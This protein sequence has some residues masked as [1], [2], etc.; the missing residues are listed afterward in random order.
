MA[1]S[2]PPPEPRPRFA[3]QNRLTR[4]RLTRITPTLADLWD[5]AGTLTAAVLGLSV[6]IAV[7]EGVS[8]TNAWSVVV[9]ALAVAIL[10]WL[11][12]APL[13][14]VAN[15]LGGV[16]AFVLGLAVQVTAVWASL[17]YLPGLLVT[18]WWAAAWVL[19]IT[20]I[21]VAAVSWLSGSNDAGYVVSDVMR[22]GKRQAALRQ[23][24]ARRG[25]PLPDTRPPGLLV[26][27]LDGLAEPVLRQAIEGGLTP[28]MA[29]WLDSGSHEL[30]QWWAQVPATTP[31]STAGL[32]HGKADAI[33]AFR[34]W[35]PTQRRLVVTNHP[36]DAAQIEEA[37]SDGE[38]L[39]AHDGVAIST[40]FSG[41]A[42]TSMLV[43]SRTIG[44]SRG[45][46]R[47]G[48][49]Y[50]RFFTRPLVFTRAFVL[51]IGEMVKEIYQARLARVRG[52]EPRISRGGWYVLLRG[53]TNVTLRGLNTSLVAEHM[54]RGAPTIAVDFVDYDEIAH[55]AGPLRP[56]SL[57]SL[58]GLDA[59]LRT[60]ATVG[61]VAPR[62]YRI[63]V[64]SDHGQALG[65]TFEQVA[66]V[67]FSDLVKALMAAGTSPT[68]D[69]SGSVQATPERAGDGDVLA[70]GGGEDWGP[71]NTLLSQVLAPM[72]P[73]RQPIVSGPERLKQTTAK[74]GQA[75]EVGDIAVIASGNLGLIWFTHT[76]D[77]LLL[78]RI[79]QLWPNLVAGLA[80][81]P[82]IA[83]V[84]VDS[85]N[86]LL[87]VG[88]HGVRHLEGERAGE[89]DG[90]DPLTAFGIDP[91][92]A[93]RD[94]ARAARLPNTGDLL[95][96]SG[97]TRGRVHA[98]EHQVGSHGGLGGDQN[99]SMLLHPAELVRAHEEYVGS[100]AVFHQLR[101]WQREL[102]LRP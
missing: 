49:V 20:A 5:A 81:H 98:F 33:P 36:W 87:A 27:I 93:A 83:A 4:T 12:A 92:Q 30:T 99:R 26:V 8:A 18:S 42:P 16:V 95:V 32:L 91:A 2:A 15:W 17:R 59:V 86:G 96:I 6:G 43:M 3:R 58:E 46:R 62:D 60:L 82:A 14:L 90:D 48:A 1:E 52:V 75:R 39:L 40:V 71:I 65:A 35:D 78:D 7:V 85:A 38:G 28:T 100:D 31:A 23:L 63:V 66:G 53:I 41:D 37:F 19:L 64:V 47:A 72:R 9:A 69:T 101:A 50:V 76:D 61:E 10:T 11:L 74:P 55:H 68:G 45:S 29:S 51:T 77:R 94:L 73:D 102:G 97:M 79:Q 80:A 88:S 25:K 67:T 34:W 13:R 54:E 57:R 44:N 22:R 56:E 89:I 70:S 24:A 21:V 84:V